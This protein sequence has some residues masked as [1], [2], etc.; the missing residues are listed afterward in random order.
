MKKI[1]SVVLV[2]CMVI[3]FSSCKGKEEGTTQVEEYVLPT[4]VIDA[5][6]SLPYTSSD[7]FN[8]YSAKSSFNR[9]LIPVIYESLFVATDDGKGVPQLAVSGEN[10]GTKVTVKLVSG[11]VFSDG[12]VLTADHIKESYEKAKN[13]SYYTHNL[14]NVSSISVKDKYTLVFNLSNPDEMALNI[15][16]FPIVRVNGDK[17]Y[18]SGKYS[19]EYLEETP[20]LQVNV[21]HRE[22]STGWNKQIAL[23][24]M[25][26]VSSPIYPFKANEISAY[27][28]DLS[29]GE[30]DN[31]SSVTKA[32]GM[33]NL[34][35][36]GVNSKWAGSSTS[37]QWLRRAIHIGI[38]RTAIVRESFLGQGTPVNTMFKPE[39]Y[40][41]ADEIVELK[42][43]PEKAIK[44]MANNGYDKVNADGFRTNG[45]NVLHVSILVCSKNQYKVD[46]ANAL[47]KALEELG[48]SASVS[49]RKTVADFKSALEDEHFGLYIGETQL[50]DNCDLSEFFTSS[51][52]LNYGIDDG[53]FTRYSNY[54]AGKTTTEKFV[55]AMS[56][57]APVIPLFYRDAVVFVNPNVSGVDETKPIYSG[58]CN[59]KLS[60][61]NT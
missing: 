3:S 45:S 47:E 51:G 42:G 16:N 13:N 52:S 20:Y 36:V 58:V 50:T 32:E 19:I 9:D 12:A 27:R 22:F 31:L 44:I 29:N 28:N 14:S 57:Y 30:Y 54:R 24:D 46:V 5:D 21:N 2:L 7:S 4:E 39:F 59:W 8:P 35:Y 48:I 33:N 41:G 56:V 10:E 6:V 23:Y 17:C 15:L 34:V 61:E 43:D 18:G 55:K 1:I 37:N 60:E 40:P 25:A 53:Y 49:E 26:G 38:D 11:V